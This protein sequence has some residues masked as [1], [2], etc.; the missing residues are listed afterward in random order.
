MSMN[1]VTL[2]YLIA[3]VCFIQALKGLSHPTTSRR[4]NLF[5]MVGMAIAVLTT[6][7]L[8][9]KISSEDRHHRH[10]LRGR[11]PAGRGHRRF[12]HGQARRD[13]Q[14][15]RAGRLHAQ[16]DRPG[17]RVHRHRRGGRAAVAGHRREPGRHHPHRQPPGAVP[18]RGHRRH[19]L[20][21]LGDRLRQAVGQVQVPPV[22]G[23][24]GAVHRPAPAQPGAGPDH[25]RPGPAVHVHRQPDR[26]RRD[27]GPGLRPRRAD[28]HPDR[29]RR[30]AGGGVDA[31]LLLRLGR[32]GHRLL[33]EQLDADHRRL[34][35]GLLGR[36]PLLHHVQGDEPLVLQRHPR[37]LRRRSGRRRPGRR[38]RSR[39]R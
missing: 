20:L 10:R 7:A 31:E 9:F 37:R 24:P 38:E 39:A 4:G 15:A 8:V 11:R 6:V 36:D 32:G 35:G 33:A 23:R 13:D 17:R 1:L 2:L 27:A 29:R 21:R 16:H 28:H 12:D 19:H 34:A 3:S 26:L 5:G 18:R 30:H 22:P 14:D 25:S